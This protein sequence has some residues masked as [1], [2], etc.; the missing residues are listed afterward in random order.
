ME[1]D[2]T[3]VF[4][5][6]VGALAAVSLPDRRPGE[7]IAR[8]KGAKAGKGHFSLIPLGFSVMDFSTFSS[9]TPWEIDFTEE[10]AKCLLLMDALRRADLATSVDISVGW[11]VC[12]HVDGGLPGGAIRS[13]FASVA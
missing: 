1:L 7:V 11:C 12:A 4:A 3:D 2:G 6:G 5:R 10:A 13:S 9:I 8:G